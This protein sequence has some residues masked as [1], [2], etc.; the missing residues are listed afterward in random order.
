MPMKRI[1][2]R[3]F[4]PDAASKLNPETRAIRVTPWWS[5]MERMMNERS[6]RSRISTATITRRNLNGTRDSSRWLATIRTIRT[7]DGN[8][9][10][11]FTELTLPW[12]P[13]K[14]LRLQ[15]EADKI[16]PSASTGSNMIR[17]TQI[18]MPRRIGNPE[19]KTIEI[20]QKL[21]SGHRIYPSENV[22][23]FLKDEQ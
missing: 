14:K 23:S 4:L 5:Q 13:T 9:V 20:G 7:R 22:H 2:P 8:S 6:L 21:R 3:D 11:N 17:S 10:L 1:R 16:T 18:L 12:I 15:S 19:S